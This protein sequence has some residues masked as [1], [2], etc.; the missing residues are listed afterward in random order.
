MLVLLLLLLFRCRGFFL[1]KSSLLVCRFLIFISQSSL[2]LSFA[3]LVIV[4]AVVAVV[5]DVGV[6]AVVAISVSLLLYVTVVVAAF[7][8]FFNRCF[9][10]WEIVPLCLNETT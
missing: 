6:V 9:L 7:G 1:P 4:V 5:F 8:F 3:A 10:S 2:L